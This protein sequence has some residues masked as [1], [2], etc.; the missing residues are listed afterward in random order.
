[1]TTNY[2]MRKIILLIA[3]SFIIQLSF[4]Q[5]Q[6]KSLGWANYDGQNYAGEPTGGGNATVTEVYTFSSLK[7]AVESS[8]AKVIHVM[9]SMGN[10]YK[11]TTGD[12]LYLKSNKTIIGIKAGITIK[13]SWQIKGASNIIIRNL[14]MEGPGNSNANQN[15]DCVNIEGSKRVWVDHCTVLNG[16]DGNFDIVKGS[17]NVSVTWTIFT[18]TAPGDHNLSNLIGSSD[19]ESASHGKLNTSYINC[20][21][22]DVADRCPR[23]RY[24]MIHMVNCLYTRP[25]GFPSSNGTAAGLM[26][27]NRVENCYFN[28]ISNPVKIIGTPATANCTPIGCKFVSCSGNTSA[29]SMGG[30]AVF[31]P[32]Y[33]YKSWMVSADA[34]KTQVE[35]LAGNTMAD[36]LNCGGPKKDCNGVAGGTAFLDDCANC[37]GGTTGKTACKKDCNG[38]INGPAYLDNCGVCIGNNANIACTNTIEA[39]LA[40]QL[41]GTIDNNNAG[42][43]GAGFANTD[44]TI[45][46]TIAWVVSSPSE[47]TVTLSFR[48]ANGET[49]S[50]DGNLIL[51][52]KTVATLVLPGTGAWTI[53]K[54]VSVNVTLL[55]GNNSL[56]IKATTADGLANLD[57][58]GLSSNVT[59]AN[60]IVTGLNSNSDRELN[61]YPN[62]TDSK[63]FWK[64]E[65]TWTLLNLEGTKLLDG[66]GTQADLSTLS[67][68]I[69]ILQ[70]SQQMFKVIRK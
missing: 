42:F 56:S 22:K 66:K 28:G 51:N 18:Y 40:C 55:K 35:S 70:I 63:V 54:V 58:L 31:T 21:W 60:C 12:V 25:K 48:Y 53:W 14:Q 13:C 19:D 38:V 2:T 34:A 37:V 4:A 27:N 26:A 41:D 50:R 62:P 61:V 6:C 64:T 9:N 45:D 16:E 49:S 1:M 8:S 65:Q 36:P 20:W 10:G 11:G 23:T 47:Q 67:S 32:P 15:W 30:L 24:G 69:Y 52:G 29:S 33:E 68:G 59:D 39:E 5:D 44:N 43:S 3:T 7:S 17:D 57:V 46:A